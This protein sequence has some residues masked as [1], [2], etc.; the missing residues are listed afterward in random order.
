MS[1]NNR[2]ALVTGGAGGI[3]QAINAC[4]VREGWHVIA[5]DLAGA[6]AQSDPSGPSVEAVEVDVTDRV[7]VAGFVEAG[8][9]AGTIAAVVNCAGIVRF[10]P[11]SGFEDADASL[12]WEVNVA[13]AARVSSLAV[14]HMSDGGAIVNVASVTGFI[15]RLEGASLYGASK[16]GLCAFTRYQATE[17]APRGIRVNALAPGFIAVPMSPAMRA[18]SGG[19][20]EVV[21]QVPLGRLGGV[22]E[23]AEVVEFLISERASYI[24]GETILADGGVVAG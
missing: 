14:P 20:E 24:T 7:S 9:R 2:V 10:T 5:G 18:V 21:K 4:L 22:D 11:M 15:G 19:D 13:G 17:L 16:A 6:I 12:I 8:T 23:M 3:G 1:S